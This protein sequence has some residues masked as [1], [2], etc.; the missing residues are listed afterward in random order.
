HLQVEELE[1]KLLDQTQEVERLRSELGATDLEKQLELLVVE[2]ERLKQELKSCRSSKLQKLDAAAETCSHCPHS[3]VTCMCAGSLSSLLQKSSR[4]EALQRQLDDST[5]QLDDSRRQLE[6]SRRRQGEAEQKLTLR[7]QECEEEL[8]RQAATPPRVKYVTQTVE[9]ES[10]DS[11]KAV[12]ELQVKNNALQEQLSAQRQLLRELETQLHES[13]RTCAQLRTQILVYEGEMERAQGQLEAEMQN[14]EEEKNRVIEEAFIRAESEMKA[15]HENLAG[16]RMNLLSLQPALRTL[17]SDYNCLKRQVQDFPFMLDKAIT[18]AKQEICQVISEVSSTNQE[19]L[20]KYKRE[21]NL[22]KKCHNELVRLKGLKQA[23]CFLSE[24]FIAPALTCSILLHFILK[25]VFQEVQALITSCIDGYN[26]CI[27]AYGQTGSGKTYTMEGV[28]DNP[29]INQRALRLLFSEVSEK[30]PDWDYKITVSMVEI[31]NE[32]LRDLLGENPSD[33]LDIKMNPDGS[34]QLYVPRLT[35]ITVQSPEDI[36]KVFELGHVNRATACTNLNEHSS[37]SHALLIIT[38]S[39]FNTA[40]GNRTL[41]KLNLVDL[42]GSERIGKS[43]AEG[44]RLRE[45]QCINKS[46]SALGDVINALR[47]K[48]SH[49]PFRNSRLT[50]LLQDSLSGDS[51]TLMMVQV[52]PLPSNMSESVCSLKFAQRVRSVELSSSSS[53]KHENSSTSSSPTHDM[54]PVPLPISRAS[55][56]G[57]TLSSA[58]RTPSSSRRR[59][60]SQLS[61]GTLRS[62]VT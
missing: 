50:Y 9:V 44:S 51:K 32:T 22:R 18:E 15:V 39:G 12:A 25:E 30:A 56:A 19:L 21:M 45:A 61:T 42:A 57:S 3:Q 4:T 2:N 48:H 60:Q 35:E 43:G 17:T 41:G 33:K 5:R 34:G 14:L 13:Q 54:T 49:V 10:A 20:R 11:Q 47:S 38:V 1:E 62:E 59:S 40:T 26:V 37:R 29:G 28:T 53:R 8:A 7:L 52:S 55:S 46:L 27:F 31:Y 58:S 16:V 23:S 24:R 36:N 6:E